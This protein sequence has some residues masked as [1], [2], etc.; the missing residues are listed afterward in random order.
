MNEYDDIIN[1]VLQL[2]ISKDEKG[3]TRLSLQKT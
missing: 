3:V 2:G 1:V